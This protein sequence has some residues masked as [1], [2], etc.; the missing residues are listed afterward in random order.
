MKACAWG[1]WRDVCVRVLCL[2]AQCGGGGERYRGWK[3]AGTDMVGACRGGGRDEGEESQKGGDIWESSCAPSLAK[4]QGK[5]AR[6][7]W[8]A[9]GLPGERAAP[10]GGDLERE[11]RAET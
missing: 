11:R 6:E 10:E 4:T 2:F 1:T 8:T 5:T 3:A 9:L 7:G